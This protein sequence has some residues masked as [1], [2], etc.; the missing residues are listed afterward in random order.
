MQYLGYSPAMK[1]DDTHMARD[2]DWALGDAIPDALAGNAGIVAAIGNFDGVHRGHQHVITQARLQAENAGLPLVILTFTP[3]PRAYFR[4][5]D[6]SFLLMDRQSKYEALRASGADVVVHIAFTP[7]LQSCSAED[8]VNQVI[9]KLG[10]KYLF[11]GADFA[12]GRG[13]S[14][15][16]DTL[17][18]LGAACN[19]EVSPVPL[20]QDAHAAII[21]SSRIR[22][23]LQSGQ[24]ELAANML[25]HDPVIAGPVLQ[26]DQRG[27]LLNFPTANLSLTGVLAPA[28][29]VYAV[30]ALIVPALE[31][32]DNQLSD[33]KMPHTQNVESNRLQGVANIGIR[34]TVNNRGI[35][36]ETHLFDFDQDI[37]SERLYVYLKHFIRAEQKF[38]GIEELQA[39][40]AKDADTARTLLPH[41][42]LTA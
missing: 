11:A 8:F 21:S 14:G 6:V 36:C 2:V 22:A 24:V 20:L 32:S 42:S 5:D 28:F 10:V 7:E 30:E 40:I 3:H 16:M 18:Q 33:K 27:R 41:T 15:D 23:A 12:F 29:G 31:A 4:P 38:N 37:Y 35:L 39:Q 17:K 13:R 25:G 1:Q 34:P 19:I 26:G 9:V